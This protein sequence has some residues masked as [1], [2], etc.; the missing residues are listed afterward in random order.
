MIARVVA[1]PHLLRASKINE[2]SACA[3][4]HIVYA[5][6]MVREHEAVGQVAGSG[7]AAL[8]EGVALRRLLAAQDLQ[9]LVFT[10]PSPD[11]QAWAAQAPALAFVNAG[12]SNNA[13]SQ[14]NES[15]TW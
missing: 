10:P 14:P 4:H 1:Q 8:G 11:V 9:P 6:C 13:A 2:E 7:D 12:L 5:L 3:G 15:W